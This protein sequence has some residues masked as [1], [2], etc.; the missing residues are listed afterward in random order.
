MARKRSSGHQT[1]LNR[2]QQGKAQKSRQLRKTTAMSRELKSPLAPYPLVDINVLITQALD[3]IQ[4]TLETG[5]DNP[6]TS[7]KSPLRVF[8]AFS[9]G[10]QRARVVLFTGINLDDLA[11]Q[12]FAWGKRQDETVST[13]RWL[14]VDRVDQAWPMTW[15]ECQKRI[16]TTKRNYFRYGITLDR[17]FKQAFMEQEINANAMLYLGG[18]TL[19]SRVNTKNSTIYGRRRFGKGFQLPQDPEHQVLIFTTKGFF[20][21]AGRPAVHLNGFD[22]DTGGRNTGRRVIKCLDKPVVDKLISDSSQ[23]LAAQVGDDGRFVYG[24]HPC[25][26]REI[27]AY[28]TLRHTSTIYAMLEAWEVTRNPALKAAIDR[29]IGY[30]VQDLIRIYTPEGEAP[31][32]YLQDANNEIKLGGSAVCLLALVKYTE[33]T[34]NQ[35]Y[36]P[37]LEKLALGVR[38]LQDPETGQ[39]SHVLNADDLS[40]KEVFRIIYYD[41]EAAFGL[42]RLYGLTKD[43]RWLETVESAFAYFIANKHW[44]THDHWLSYCV[45]EL[46]LYRPEERYF[47][48]GIQN[49]VGHLDFVIERITTFPTLL[50]LMMAAHKMIIRLQSSDEHR[51]LIDQIDIDKFYRALEAR[52]QY[53]LNGFFWP[54]FAMYYKNPQRILGG[55][56]IRHQSFRVR[57]DDVEHYLSGYVAYLQHYLKE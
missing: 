39:L 20:I 5:A 16:E 15:A 35:Q 24:L 47:E 7:P 38:R 10:N 3:A 6:V 17:S 44:K 23:F 25:F 33:L 36:L 19:N 40:V 45:N 28:N 12:A 1:M 42:M 18:K 8:F 46:T 56:F 14:R 27:N 41:G 13:A 31:V 53:L 29:A 34:S 43:P 49:F 52:A 37:L 26:D 57:I 22:E 30:L 11:Q 51:H 9:D 2:V 48:F 55:F 54:E 50:E 32:A 4:S 21:Q